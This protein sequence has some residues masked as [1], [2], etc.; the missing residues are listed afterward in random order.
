[1]QLRNHILRCLA[2]LGLLAL[3]AAAVT[4]QERYTILEKAAS[5][6]GQQLQD[7]HRYA[8]YEY[9]W[10]IPNVQECALR[11]GFGHA[12]LIV[13]DVKI[14]R[15]TRDFRSHTWDIFL[16]DGK[17]LSLTE[18]WK[19]REFKEYKGPWH[20]LADSVKSQYKWAGEVAGNAGNKQISKIGE[21]Y[22]EEWPN[23]NIASNNCATY[24][25]HVMNKIRAT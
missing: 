4:D 2:L 19:V 18:P 21:D 12:R 8:M 9:W 13:G 11:S 17:M 1:M 22:V 15:N 14:S 25:W 7:G 10:N 24:V 3:F 16:H 6:A 20:T 5:D 23:Y